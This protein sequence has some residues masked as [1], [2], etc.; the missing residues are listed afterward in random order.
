MPEALLRAWLADPRAP[1]LCLVPA[2]P[3]VTLPGVTWLSLAGHGVPGAVWALANTLGVAARTPGELLSA[4]LA[5]GRR[6]VLAL[7][8]LADAEDPKGLAELVLALADL[9]CLRLLVESPAPLTA[10]LSQG[11][12]VLLEE[13][14]EAHWPDDDDFTSLTDEPE[15]PAATEPVPAATEPAP[16]PAAVEPEAPALPPPPPPAPLPPLDLDD[17]YAVCAADPKRVTVGYDRDGAA[18]GGLGRAWVRAGQAVTREVPVAVRAFTLLTAL[19]EEADAGLRAALTDLAGDGPWRLVASRVKG[20][21][22]PPWPGPAAALTI[23]PGGR[24]LLADDLGTVHPLH[25]ADA[26]PAGEPAATSVRPRSL[27]AL[28]DGTLLLLDERGRLRTERGPGNRLT[29][30]VADTLAQ[31]PGSAFAAAAGPLLVGDRMGSVHV[32]GT[33]GVHQ[34]ALHAGRVTA[35]ASVD[36]PV[37][38][39]CS[40]GADGAV[41]TWTP[42]CTPRPAPVAERD[43]AVVALAAAP[44]ADGP[45]LLVAWADGLVELYRSGG[46]G[47]EPLRF[48]PGPPVRSLALTADGTAV[49]GTDE[50]LTLLRPA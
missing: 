24:L 45:N 28:G 19:G 36:E 38:M 20:D 6:R 48:R 13:L 8:G 7:P 22:T 10:R 26:T 23:T 29:R 5:D 4:L 27:A 34:A 46:P 2:L 43:C 15:P 16:A 30:A 39:A 44:G 42:G 9:G 41:R 33:E 14:E 3:A 49:V 1:R 47:P 37:P 21:R 25:A 12:A 18:H 50:S 11:P 32:F 40:G 31:H 17:P 35:L